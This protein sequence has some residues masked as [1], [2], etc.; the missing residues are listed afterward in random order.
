MKVDSQ[1]K[2]N[3]LSAMARGLLV[4]AAVSVA[5]ASSVRPGRTAESNIVIQMLDM[6]PSFEPRSVTIKVGET[7]V[8][9]NVGNAVH[10]A[11]DDHE[12]A[13]AGSDVAS[14]KDASIFDSGFMRPGETF[15]HT[16]T[17]PGIYRYVCVAHEASG[18]AG[19]IIVR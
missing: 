17:T 9:K 13:I 2:F 12:M 3:R 10:H 5:L 8:W 19:E 11:T 14:P 4:L 18:M 16:F 1:S 7:V 6:P 15:S